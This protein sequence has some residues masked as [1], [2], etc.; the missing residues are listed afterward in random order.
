MIE[1]LSEELSVDSLY[2]VTSVSRLGDVLSSQKITA[3]NSL[4]RGEDKRRV[5]LVCNPKFGCVKE[6][7]ERM[8]EELE[9][10]YDNVVLLKFHR[11]EVGLKS[12]ILGTEWFCFDSNGPRKD[13]DIAGSDNAVPV[14]AFFNR[15]NHIVGFDELP[16]LRGIVVLK[17]ENE[18]VVKAIVK[19][20][21]PKQ[22][23]DP[24]DVV[25][26]DSL[27]IN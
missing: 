25:T 12:T 22:Q 10:S 15:K 23:G 5:R 24:P 17:K 6:L 8:Q 14:E 13:V 7:K 20:S 9:E 21:W 19:T 16:R 4:F 2:F 27:C 3:A 11:S 1:K 26:D 18:S